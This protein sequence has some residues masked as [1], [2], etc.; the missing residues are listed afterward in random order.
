VQTVGHGLG[1]FLQGVTPLGAAN[2]A[3][4]ISN[5]VMNVGGHFHRMAA[6][7]Q[8]DGEE[9]IADLSAYFLGTF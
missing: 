8:R 3:G 4:K 5:R 9:K 6:A 2:P 7:M 1:H